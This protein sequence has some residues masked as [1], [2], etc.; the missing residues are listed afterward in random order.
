[1]TQKEITLAEDTL[2]S[3]GYRVTKGRIALL[4]FLARNRKPLSI[5]QIEKELLYLM[6]RVTV[7]RA[8][9]EFFEAKLVDKVLLKEGVPYYEYRHED[10]HHHVLCTVCGKIEDIAICDE[11]ILER[12]ILKTATHFASISSHTMEFFGVCTKC[13]KLK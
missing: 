3:K 6:D 13:D 12:T 7:Y 8:L 1:M 9:E 5:S 11:E 4:G 10:H 2:R